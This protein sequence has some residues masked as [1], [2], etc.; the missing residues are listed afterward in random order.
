MSQMQALQSPWS[1]LSKMFFTQPITSSAEP[2]P[3]QVSAAP[4]KDRNEEDKISFEFQLTLDGPGTRSTFVQRHWLQRS[5]TCHAAKEE[6]EA[7]VDAQHNY[8]CLLSSA[9]ASTWTCEWASK[10]PFFYI[11]PTPSISWNFPLNC[12]PSCK[13]ISSALLANTCVRSLSQIEVVS[14][15]W[16]VK[17]SG[18]FLK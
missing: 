3:W 12:C 6:E 1:M 14:L 16:I 5:K 17:I 11:K 2:V 15:N 9:F 4:S 7:A 13:I 18:S 10:Q 8:C